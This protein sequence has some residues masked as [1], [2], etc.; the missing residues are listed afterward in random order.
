MTK[1]LSYVT[2]SMLAARRS[3]PTPPDFEFAMRHMGLTSRLLT[4]HLKPP[5]PPSTTELVFRLAEA[6]AELPHTPAELLGQEL[7]GESD[8]RTKKYIPA[9]FPA[10]PSKHTYKATSVIPD[11]ENDPRKIR[12]KAT[13]AA[14]N[15][16]EALR[17]LVKV[18][19]TGTHAA[20]RGLEN[21]KNKKARNELWEQSMAAF[22]KDRSDVEEKTISVDAEKRY[23]RRPV[24][25]TGKSSASGT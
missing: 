14:R 17:R 11:R 13:Q 12:E 19:K 15:A 7:N 21:D 3:Q 2:E 8:K 18:G 22:S 1:V 25:R 16:E 23:W 4:P 6:E 5:V 20:K 10:F 9:K 24:L